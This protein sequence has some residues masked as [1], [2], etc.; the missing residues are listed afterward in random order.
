MTL[1]LRANMKFKLSLQ[2]FY[3][4]LFYKNLWFY[5]NHQPYKNFKN[6]RHLFSCLIKI[7]LS[8][9]NSIII[10]FKYKRYFIS[11]GTWNFPSMCCLFILGLLIQRIKQF[12]SLRLW[13]NDDTMM[14]NPD[15]TY[16]TQVTKNLSSIICCKDSSHYFTHEWI[17]SS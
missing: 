7:K 2:V 16:T 6:S 4:K 9:V 15:L 5:S 3:T 1:L 17:T 11:A 12:L 10:N 13:K 8:T 14:P